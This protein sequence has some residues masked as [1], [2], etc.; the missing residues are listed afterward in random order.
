MKSVKFLLYALVSLLIIL[1]I[2]AKADS[3]V[4]NNGIEISEEEYN[5]FIKIHTHESIMTMN[6]EKYQKLLSLD[7]SDITTEDYYVASTYNQSLNLTTERE[8]TEE[9]FES[10]PDNGISP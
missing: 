6:E 9:E 10:Y 4:N 3:I 5:N 8:I 1:P 2:D 7:Y